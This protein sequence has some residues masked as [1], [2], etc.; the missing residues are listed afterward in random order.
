MVANEL[1]LKRDMENVN[2]ECYRTA[3]C[4]R[5][6]REDYDAPARIRQ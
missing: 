3:R 5:F 6:P 2:P 1:N 4:V